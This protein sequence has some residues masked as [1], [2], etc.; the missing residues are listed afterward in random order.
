MLRQVGFPFESKL[1]PE[2]DLVALSTAPVTVWQMIKGYRS[3][4]FPMPSV[5]P[6]MID[7]FSPALRGVLL[8]SNLRVTRSF[9]KSIK[10][11]ETS[12]D[13]D[14]EQVLVRCADRSRPGSW[15]D[16]NFQN[17]Y[18]ELFE[19][20]LAHS[21]EVWDDQ[22]TLVGGLFGVSVGKVFWG[23]SMFHDAD[24]GRDASKVALARLVSV[25]SKSAL[26]DTQWLTPHLQTLGVRQVPRAVYLKAVGRLIHQDPIVFESGRSSRGGHTKIEDT[27]PNEPLPQ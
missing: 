22:N 15:I 12:I 1:W 24:R 11:Y 3:G 10:R 13:C 19:L 16:D 25:M 17:N 8:P 20:G 21:I 14:F 27:Y 26:I 2:S 6:E 4:S 18:L 5:I 9:R 7:W 23:E